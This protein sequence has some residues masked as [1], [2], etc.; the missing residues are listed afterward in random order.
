MGSLHDARYDDDDDFDAVPL[1]VGSARKRSRLSS[2]RA[3][4]DAAEHSDNSSPRQVA[5]VDG[6][7]SPA[8][9]SRR[10]AT[11]TRRV[12]HSSD[13]EM[14]AQRET[15]PRGSK[16]RLSRRRREVKEEA[17]VENGDAWLSED[18]QPLNL[19]RPSKGRL[20]LEKEAK[21]DPANGSDVV[22]FNAKGK[23]P[24]DSDDKAKWWETGSK[25]KGGKKW[26]T[27]VHHGVVFP[28][29]YE[30]HGV[31]LV[32]D[33]EPVK[34]DPVAEEVATFYAAKLQTDYVKKDL[35][36]KNFFADFRA[37]MSGTPAHRVVKRFDLC[38]FSRIHA[39]LEQR[40][41][42]KQAMSAAEKKAVKEAE[43]EKI[44]RYETALIDGREEKVANFRVEPPALFL[45]RGEHP[46]MGQVKKRIMPEDITIN[47]GEDAPVPEP[48]P[49]HQWGEV[50]HKHDVTWLAGW[51]DT[52]TNGRK[53]VFLGAGSVFKGMSDHAKF[54]KARELK[55]Y[56]EAVRK[57]YREGWDIKKK[58]V[59]Q[60][61][62][63]MYLIDKLALR[64]G[65]EKG[66]DE[67]DTV[68]CCSLRVEHLKFLE[69]N[70]IEFD[71]LGKDSIRYLNE[72]TVEEKVY[73]NLRMFC[74][75]KNPK[76][77]IFHRL[78][79]TG[80]NEYLKGIM[81]GLSAKV[82]RTYNASITLSGLL[83]NTPADAS[84]NEKIVY[85]NQ[86]NKEVA[87]LCNHQRALPKAHQAQMDKLQKKR[88]ELEEWIAELKKAQGKLRKKDAPEKVELTQKVAV[89]AEITPDMTDE[90][91]A[92]ERKRVAELPKEEKVI[93]RNKEQVATALKS[94]N[95]RLEKLDADMTVKE[96]LKTIALGTS[97]IN[98]LDPRITVAWCKQHN[99]P[100]ERIFAKT[101]LVKFAWAMETSQNYKF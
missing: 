78:T 82:F 20:K 27:L 36:N 53:Y 35:F 89:K 73:R 96:E 46:K 47:I 13:D 68:G 79:V 61:S 88:D 11:H 85:Y 18:D 39:L 72:V 92:V 19:A 12:V 55:K 59:R 31:P 90:Q 49:G 43:K 48:L 62:V 4:A 77:L 70:T 5:P 37:S 98:Y 14:Q 54:E 30:P 80:L 60:R 87:I 33:G 67:A 75:N 38:D 83:E 42:E 29:P 76:D 86:Q 22:R 66:E 52:I 6:D 94:A 101:L 64:V 57:D 74:H 2:S 100:I 40:K 41:A 25:D 99:V 97:K 26:A 24:K 93:K 44:A 7:G 32:Y 1:V 8:K 71:F 95:A 21:V 10:L 45:G 58:E 81:P 69:N 34:L 3:L 56:I 23:D 63:V 84:L 50:I 17:H 91:K 28:P 9:R 65:N 15:P 16:S 51:K